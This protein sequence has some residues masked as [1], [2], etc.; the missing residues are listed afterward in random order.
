MLASIRIPY[1]YRAMPGSYAGP[2]PR[3]TY[4][5]FSCGMKRRRRTQSAQRD[6]HRWDPPR[7][8]LFNTERRAQSAERRKSTLAVSTKGRLVGGVRQAI[9][10]A[11]TQED[12]SS[13]TLLF[14]TTRHTRVSDIRSESARRP[15]ESYSDRRFRMQTSAS[16]ATRRNTRGHWA[17]L[18]SERRS[19]RSAVA[20]NGYPSGDRGAS[21]VMIGKVESDPT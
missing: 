21:R 4:R 11:V 7:D 6:F 16:S 12:K 10:L 2:R 8:S 9:V 14:R 20:R 17:V 3:V 15:I 5:L 18:L 1:N 19:R 13:L